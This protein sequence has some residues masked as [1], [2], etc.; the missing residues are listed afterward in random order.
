MI[1]RYGGPFDRSGLEDART[2]SQAGGIPTGLR[3]F[4]CESAIGNLPAL[5][6]DR[7]GCWT[8]IGMLIL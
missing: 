7:H 8:P 4:P 5:G 2:R 6:V 1:E 3:A